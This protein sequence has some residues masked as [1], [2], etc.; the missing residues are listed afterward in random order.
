MKTVIHANAKQ[1][2]AALI[3]AAVKDSRQILNGVHVEATKNFTR[4]VS[5]DSHRGSLQLHS[6]NNELHENKIVSFTVPPDVI[7]S[8]SKTTINIRFES[9]NLHE[10]ALIADNTIAN[11]KAVGAQYPDWRKVFPQNQEDI[12]TPAQ[13]NLDYLADFAKMGKILGVK[14]AQMQTNIHQN[15]SGAGIVTISGIPNFLGVVMP[16]RADK[17]PELHKNL[18]N[19]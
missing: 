8:L 13:Y 19:D 6:A 9:D 3:T 16:L 18:F 14:F 11:F 15:A 12:E 4:I 10:W 2:R 1:L 5:I 7:K 17:K